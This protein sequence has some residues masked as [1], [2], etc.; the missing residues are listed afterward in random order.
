MEERR[1]ER[2]LSVR[3]AVV[4]GTSVALV[5]VIPLIALFLYARSVTNDRISDNADRIADEAQL[6]YDLCIDG[7][8]RDT[9]ITRDLTQAV[10][11]V[12]ATMPPG[13]E[14]ALIVQTYRDTITLLEPPDEKDCV[15]PSGTGP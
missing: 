3:L 5:V 15:Q 10:V 1:E 9:E 12:L 14:R 2:R 13:T 4:W 7:E 6:R 8:K 11:H